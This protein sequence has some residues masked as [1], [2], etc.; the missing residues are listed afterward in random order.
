MIAEINA[1]YRPALIVLDAVEA[2]VDGGP[3]RG[4][5][6]APEVMLVGDDRVAVDAVGVALLRRF[7]TTAVVSQGPIFAQEQMARAVEVGLGAAGPQD[8]DLV[9]DD[10]EGW[11]YARRLRD[12]L[13]QENPHMPP[14]A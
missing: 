8:I 1:A 4:R 9:S 12:I 14:M 6:V 2:F 7:G 3:D 10:D 5:R 13:A 11:A